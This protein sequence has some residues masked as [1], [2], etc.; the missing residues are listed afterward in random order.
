MQN[1]GFLGLYI[2]CI[3]VN[4]CRKA[5]S[6]YITVLMRSRY[7]IKLFYFINFRETFPSVVL[8][9]ADL[10]SRNFNK[11]FYLQ[12]IYQLVHFF[13]IL[14][15]SL[16]VILRVNYDI[17]IRAGEP[18]NFF[19]VPAPAFFPQ[20]LRLQLPIFLIFPDLILC[21]FS[22]DYYNKFFYQK[23]LIKL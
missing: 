13:I 5:K 10:Q 4:Y 17:I 20:R 23:I 9:L 7:F 1:I 14:L 12:L 19:A 3:F 22:S 21:F 15:Q 18:D 11:S 8:V 16:T 2:L 6:L